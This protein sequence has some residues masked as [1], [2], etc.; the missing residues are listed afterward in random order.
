MGKPSLLDQLERG[1][2]AA[3]RPVHAS[4]GRRRGL[5]A[6]VVAAL[7]LVAAKAKTLGLLALKFAG[8]AWTM[9]LSM[10]AYSMQVGWSFA[11]LLVALILVHEIGHGV[12]AGRVGVRV[13]APVFIPFIGAFIA[14]RD[15]PRDRWE[16]FVISAGGPLVGGL[17]SLACLAA[18][19]LVTGTAHQLLYGCGLLALL[20]N[21]FNLLPV[22]ILDG[23]KLLP[24]VRTVDGVVGLVLVGVALGA[25]ALWASHLNG[26]AVIAVLVIAWQVAAGARK[27]RRAPTSL[28][29]RLQQ[30][31][32]SGPVAPDPEQ[33]S[34]RR[35]Q[36]G[37]LA[38][39]GMVALYAVVLQLADPLGS[40]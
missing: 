9:L 25:S 13:G 38:Y 37:A 16:D 18:S 23:A 2:P 36:I 33:I 20:L 14:L 1:G 6:G 4:P 34:T 32:P 19:T 24:L 22:W 7:V 40:P 17:A 30:P 35:R 11:A 10:W 39:F 21:L 27:A 26:L 28:L 3:G 31:P 8:T 5:V 15:R 29:E 12:A